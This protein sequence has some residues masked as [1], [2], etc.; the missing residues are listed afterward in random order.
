MIRV[1]G[2]VGAWPVDLQIE[3][4]DQ[5]WAALARQASAEP[6]TTAAAARP[7]DDDP[8]WSR[9]QALLREAGEL[10]GPELLA[11][12]AALAGSDQAGKRLL[13]R[14]RHSDQVEIVQRGEAPLYRWI[15]Q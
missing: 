14:L 12:L 3:L 8:L 6:A 4:D 1:R 10:E 15:A 11:A 13:V 7:S 9:A 2:T 5:D